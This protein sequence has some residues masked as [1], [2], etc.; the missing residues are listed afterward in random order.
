ML[1]DLSGWREAPRE[2]PQTLV[3]RSGDVGKVYSRISHLKG[4]I[5]ME[6][7]LEISQRMACIKLPCG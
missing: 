5:E 1:S 7:M 6:S 2:L 3:E 4:E